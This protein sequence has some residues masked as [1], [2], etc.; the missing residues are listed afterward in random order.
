MSDTET[1]ET[2]GDEEDRSLLLADDDEHFSVRTRR[3]LEAR[4]FRVV[5]AE[6]LVEA[7]L[8]I[9]AEPPAFAV[10][11][12]RIGEGAGLSLIGDLLAH[13]PDCRLVVLTAFGSIA[14]AV[15]A[16][17]LGAVDY[18][19]KPADPEDLT[20][21][22]LGKALVKGAAFRPMSADRAR[23]EHIHRVLEHYGYNISETARK[24]G[25]HRRTLQRILAKRAP[26]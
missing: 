24:L 20:A 22:L 8:R 26:F 16:V 13:R 7:R 11:E 12:A 9:E 2:S 14:N 1:A 18:M 6:S 5:W 15:A 23:W 10:L 25:L 3:L 17:K 4:G 19:T 21:A